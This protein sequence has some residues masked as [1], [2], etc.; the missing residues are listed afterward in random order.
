MILVISSGVSCGALSIIGSVPKGTSRMHTACSLA[1]KSVESH[2]TG[3]KRKRKTK[4]NQLKQ[5]QQNSRQKQQNSPSSSYKTNFIINERDD[6]DEWLIRSTQMILGDSYIDEMQEECTISS[7]LPSQFGSLDEYLYHARSVMKTWTRN[8]AGYRRDAR[9]MVEVIFKRVLY[10]ITHDETATADASERKAFLVSL[11]NII[12]HSWANGRTVDE[13]AVAHVESWLHFLKRG[14][15]MMNDEEEK[16]FIIGPDEESYRGVVKAYIRTQKEEYLNKALNLLDEMSC[17][18]TLTTN[19]VLYGLANSQPSRKNA[20]IAE[21]LLWQKMISTGQE[22]S[23]PDS[24]SFR[25]VISA[26]SKTGSP[27]AIIKVNGILNRMLDEFKAIDPDASSFNAIMTLNLRLGNV[28]EVISVF[29]KMASLQESGRIVTRPDIYSL[30]LLLK[31]M[32]RRRQYSQ[33]K[34]LNEAGDLLK[35]MPDMYHLHPDTQSFNIVIDAWSKS[36][37]PEAM[38]RVE[39]LV[40]YMERCCR[41]DSLA[42]RPDSYTFTSLLD[43]IARSEHSYKRAEQMFHRI[44]KLYEDGIVEDPPTTP[45]Y[46]AFLN[47]L[48]SSHDFLESLERVESVFDEMKVQK[49]AN[50]RSCNIMLKAYSQF[51]YGKNGYFSRPI[52]SEELLTQVS[53]LTSNLTPRVI[54]V[55]STFLSTQINDTQMEER[56]DL[57]SPDAYSYTSAINAF[58]RSIGE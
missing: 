37:L 48:V 8:T 24:N 32:T 36:K 31:A 30:N 33:R 4:R 39:H 9:V 7:G 49:R 40:D 51:H 56:S 35:A 41:N 20:E 34:R 18:D 13:D 16:I 15:I 10:V 19:L 53:D 58:A 55:S 2:S 14:E 38:T 5:K 11:V 22:T 6:V 45:V 54:P 57:P 1:P 43:T 42:C 52:K 29:N 17:N 23:F 47:A 46:N 26:W 50:I 21:N 27:D 12:I 25:Q 3:F 44:E 28:E